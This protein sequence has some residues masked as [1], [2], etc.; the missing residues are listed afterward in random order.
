MSK[1]QISCWMKSCD[2][3]RVSTVVAGTLGYLDPEY[4]LT[5]ELSEKS[6]IYSFGILLLE[7][8]TNQRVIDQTRKKPNIAEWVTYVIKKGDTSKIVDPKLQGNYEP[9]SVWRA[10][11]VAMSCANPSSAKRP[12]MSQVIIKLKECL[13][14]EN[15]RI[16]TNQD[17]NSPHSSVELRVTATFDS[18]MYP[19]AR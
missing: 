19:K 14:S 10:L 13:E 18:D 3:S 8:I 2:Q 9:R 7:I 4:Y 5:S 6:D 16:N 17:T 12:N 11:E 15:A 1:V